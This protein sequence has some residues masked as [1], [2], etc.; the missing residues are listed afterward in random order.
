[1]KIPIVSGRSF[2]PADSRSAPPGVVVSESL[3]QRLF[4]QQQ[5]VGRQVLLGTN[6]QPA[7]IVG[8]AGDVKHRALDEGLAPTV[9][10]PFAQS[11]STSSI[12]VVRSSR[13]AA[14]AIGI[15]REEVGRLDGDLPVYGVRSMQD[16]VAAS[17]GVSERWVLTMAFAGFALLA[18][19]LGALG[20]FGVAAHEVAARRA[21]LA[22]RLALGAEP[23]RIV[24]MI[25]SQGAI[26]IGSGLAAGGVLSIWAASGLGGLLYA[27][28]EFD[29]ISIGAAAAT[30]IAAGGLA[31]LPQAVRA[32]RT[33]PIVVLRGE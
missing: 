17:P 10:L 23:V 5:P 31:V 4:P 15:V 28:S 27:T 29:I 30:M 33:D 16:V 22:L 11:P 14:D 6:P 1:M 8:V 2:R 7:E 26:M 25:A 32:A 24:G 9:Y 18:V 3:A 12:V 13:Q 21:E 19:V 20:L